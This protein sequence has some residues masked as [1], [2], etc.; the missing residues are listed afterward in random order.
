MLPKYKLKVVKD[1][2][3]RAK[4]DA[5]QFLAQCRLYLAETEAELAQREKA[6][7]NCLRQQEDNQ[8]SLLENMRNGADVRLI[9]AYRAYSSD[10][11]NKETELRDL[12]KEQ[13]EVVEKAQLEVEKAMEKLAEAGKE[14][15]VI[16]KHK[17]NWERR[18]RREINLKEQKLSDEIGA[19]L[20][21]RNKKDKR[22]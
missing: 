11:K 5:M 7:E 12:L 14:L 3:E 8:K 19:I 16:E 2:R 15:K 20:F 10:L 1:V 18:Q 13:E 9:V 6:V 21:E 4:K 17:E 22:R